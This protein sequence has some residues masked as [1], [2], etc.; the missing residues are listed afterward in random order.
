[1]TYRLAIF[2]D[3]HGDV[4][5]LSDALRAIESMGADEIVC[6]GDLVDYGL[7]PD[8]TI[9]LLAE[10]KIPCVRGNHDRWAAA[11]SS[12]SSSDLS[13]AS[14][15]F[16][17]DLPTSWTR[18]IERVRVAVH[19]ASPRG[20]MDGIE[21]AEIDAAYA[22][23]FLDRADA[24]VLVV[25]HTHAAFRVELP[26]RGIIVNPGALLRAPADGGHFP[27][28]PGTFGI[29]E[30]PSMELTVYGTLDAPVVAP[31]VVR[32]L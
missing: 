12:S 29:V 14:R 3:V 7:F 4:H 20:D 17:A 15:S 22:R 30:L 11:R 24:D 1:M 2:S 16:L 10:R 13:R 5:A 8:E 26:G 28:A 19:H 18:T 6:A 27:P 32:R 9:A 31:V 25:G 23:M 21:A